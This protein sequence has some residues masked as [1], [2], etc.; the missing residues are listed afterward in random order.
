MDEYVKAYSKQL[1]STRGSHQCLVGDAEDAFRFVSSA[2]IE[3]S[4]FKNENC[5][6][7]N[8]HIHY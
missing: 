6:N 2:Y 3:R 4:E 8:S 1:D 5:H 7:N